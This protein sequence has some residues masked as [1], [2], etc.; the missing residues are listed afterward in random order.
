MRFEKLLQII[1]DEPV[2]ETGLLLAGKENPDDIRRQLSRWVKAGKLYQLRRGVYAPAPPYRKK[3]PHPFVVA[4]KLA[5]ASYISLQSALAFYGLIPEY[6]PITTSITGGRPGVRRTPLG[7]YIFRHIQP[8]LFWGY[9]QQEVAPNQHAFVAA[10]EK[11][12]LDLIYLTPGAD[13]PAYLSELRLQNLTLL[14]PDKLT[15]MAM[16]SNSAKLQQAASI[17]IELATDEQSAYKDL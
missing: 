9:T 10:P 5:A 1:A 8:R 13:N 12:L 16:Q 11:S 15:K 2:F 3:A 4:N 6:T 7:N 14:N 17:I